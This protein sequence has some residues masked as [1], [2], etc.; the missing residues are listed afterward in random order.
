MTII[1]AISRVDSVKPNVYPQEDKV[2]WLSNLDGTIKR[3]VIDKHE[4]GEKILFTPYT[5]DTPLDTVLL[6]SAPYEDLYITWLESKIDYA[7]AE[8]I[9]Y[10]NSV[11]RFNDVYSSFANDYNRNH[12]P[13]GSR[14]KYF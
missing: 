14:L 12:M 5:A 4:G 2:Q 11:T 8:Y 1:E 3:D 7:N 10:N 9:R 6:V 13:I